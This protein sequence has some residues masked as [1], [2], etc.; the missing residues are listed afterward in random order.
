[1]TADLRYLV[2][3]IP[4]LDS[5]SGLYVDWLASWGLRDRYRCEAYTI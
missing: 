3:T 1:M 2:K 4:Y 5:W